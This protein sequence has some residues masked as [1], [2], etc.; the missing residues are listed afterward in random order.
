[1]KK[2]V[3]GVAALVQSRIDELKAEK[4]LPRHEGA[5]FDELRKQHDEQMI[6]LESE[7]RAELESR[8][9]VVLLGVAHAL[10]DVGHAQNEEFKRRLSFLAN[11]YGATTILEEWADDRRASLASVFAKGR[12]DYRDIGTPSESQFKTFAN[13]PMTYREFSASMRDDR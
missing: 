1:M 6:Q 12:M 13:A 8:R 9:L 4:W 10:Q 11:S 5:E 3:T 2:P 7:L